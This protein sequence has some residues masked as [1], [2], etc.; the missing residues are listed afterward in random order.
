MKNFVQ[1]IRLNEEDGGGTAPSTNSMGSG[2]VATFEPPISYQ[3]RRWADKMDE[4]V[5]TK[6][7]YA[8]LKYGRCEGDRWAKHNISEEL[9]SFLR[10]SLYTD[11]AALVTNQD[12]GASVILRHLKRLRR[13]RNDDDATLMSAT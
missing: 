2:A 12:T 10:N 3:K 11:G 1:F 13:M 9:E 8:N 4:Y 5:V 7:D 6:E